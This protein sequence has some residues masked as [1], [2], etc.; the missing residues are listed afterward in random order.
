MAELRKNYDQMLTTKLLMERN[1]KNHKMYEVRILI[2]SLKYYITYEATFQEYL[3]SAVKACPTFRT[4]DDILD[5]YETL[6]EARK[7]LAERQEQDLSALEDARNEMVSETFIFQHD[8]TWPCV[9]LD[10][11]N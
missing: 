7:V 1:I 5:R 2:S 3:Q 6:A 4:V 11:N 9:I 8:N 10:K